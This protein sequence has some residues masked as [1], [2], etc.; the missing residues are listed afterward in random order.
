MN[1]LS[2]TTAEQESPRGGGPFSLR[3]LAIWLPGCLILGI[4]TARAAVDA[5]AYFWPWLLFPF[6][7]GLGLGGLLI[8]LMP[9][10]GQVGH[11]PTL[12]LGILLAVFAAAAGQHYFC[13]LA[14]RENPHLPDPLLEKA[15][16]AFPS[17]G[18]QSLAPRP[19][20]IFRLSEAAGRPWQDIAA[21]L[22][23]PRRCRLAHVGRRGRSLSAAT[24]PRRSFPPCACPFAAAAIRGIARSAAFASHL[25]LPRESPKSP[26]SSR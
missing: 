7:V 8:G 19:T 25:R 20:G 3:G 23:G 26:A 21:E 10:L 24:C 22:Y 14:A 15:R 11:R 2:E 13:Y 9:R 12:V 4:L 16:Q 18:R 5:Q 6:L 17:F 1:Q